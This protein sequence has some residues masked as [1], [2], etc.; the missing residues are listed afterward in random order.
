MSLTIV[1]YGR[2]PGMHR[3]GV[4]IGQYTDVDLGEMVCVRTLYNIIAG[5]RFDAVPADKI[6]PATIGELRE[7]AKAE[8]DAAQ[9]RVETFLYGGG[10]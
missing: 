3:V 5:Q 8:I 4:V 1:K 6:E 10:A 9:I 7:N 2:P